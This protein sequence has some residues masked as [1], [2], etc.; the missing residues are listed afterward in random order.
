MFKLRNKTL[1]YQINSRIFVLACCIFLIGG[2][3]TLWQAKRAVQDEMQSS[4][5]LAVQL[6]SFN[7]SQNNARTDWLVQLNALKETRHLHI[8]LKEPSG[9]LLTISQLTATPTQSNPPKW[10]IDL[11]S[12]APIQF[13]RTLITNN[14]EALTLLIEANPLNEI[15]EVWQESSAFFGLLFLLIVSIFVV[16]QFVFNRV[17]KAIL[18]IVKGLARVE[19]GNFQQQL[20]KFDNVEMTQIAN[21]INHT[22]EKLNVTQQENYALTQHNLAIQ[23]QERQHLAQELHDELG[24]SLT[25][26]KVM[27]VTISRAEKPQNPLIQQS[28][29][30]VIQLCD[31][32][33]CVVRS[34]MQQLHPLIL[35]ELGLKAAIDD[36]VLHWKIRHSYLEIGFDCDKEIEILPENICIHIFR[37]VQECLTNIV[38]HANATAVLISLTWHENDFLTLTIIDNGQGCEMKNLKKGFGLLS[39]RE[40]IR[41]LNGEFLIETALQNGMKINVTIPL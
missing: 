18:E 32:L 41:C 37:I 39:M 26:I 35:T 20:P 36:L 5:H 25:A 13:E 16:I 31:H 9:N 34:M 17:L 30:S 4:I 23:E 28:T 21:A 33:M 8:Q 6:I 38:R 10:F 29:D 40:R 3:F 14:G 1:R 27:A 24:Q 2:A 19:S 7:L 12:S 22:L 11:I 15:S